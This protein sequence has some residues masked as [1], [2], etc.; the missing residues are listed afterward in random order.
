[1]STGPNIIGNESDLED[2]PYRAT[3]S[4][5]ISPNF[6]PVVIGSNAEH[7]AY[8]KMQRKKKML[9]K[10]KKANYALGLTRHQKKA[11][12][13]RDDNSLRKSSAIEGSSSSNTS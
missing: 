11:V 2:D 12:V 5:K 6:K 9:M 8:L 1:M 13:K 3:R 4:W 7:M 10:K